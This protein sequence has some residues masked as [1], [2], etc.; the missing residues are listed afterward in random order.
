MIRQHIFK[1]SKPKERMSL[2]KLIC[3]LAA[4]ACFV[5]Y[6]IWPKAVLPAV[7]GIILCIERFVP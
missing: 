5:C 7:G 1:L 2:P 4:G 3:V 6:L